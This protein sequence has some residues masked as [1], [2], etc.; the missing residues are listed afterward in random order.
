MHGNQSI[1]IQI[2]L[3]FADHF[4][5]MLEML[6]TVAGLN[7]TAPGFVCLDL[8]NVRPERRIAAQCINHYAITLRSFRMT[9]AGI[10]LLKNRMVNNGSWHLIYLPKKST[11]LQSGNGE[12]GRS[13]LKT[14]TTI[15]CRKR[16]SRFALNAG[17]GDRVPSIR[18]CS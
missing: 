15:E 16:S 17:E 2:A 14:F 1:A 4:L 9:G 7:I 3:A 12:R 8:H 18:L 11:N 10:V 5:H 13:T 6:R